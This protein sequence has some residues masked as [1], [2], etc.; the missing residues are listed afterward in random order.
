MSVISAQRLRECQGFIDKVG[1]IRF[2]KVK[3][4][5]LNKYNILLNKKEGNITWA[6][7]TT[8]TNS[9]NLASQLGRQAST[10]LPPRE[11]SNLSQVSRQAG[12]LLPPGEGSNLSQAGTLLPLWEGSS[13]SQAIAY[14]P[15]GEG[16]SSSQTTA[17]LPPGEASSIS[18]AI[19]HLP[20][21]EGSNLS[22]AGRQS[23]TLLSHGEGSGSSQ[24]I[25][26][27]PP[28]KEAILCQQLCTF[29]PGKEA[30]LPRLLLTFPQGK[31]TVLPRLPLILP[32][33]KE[34]VIPRQVNQAIKLGQAGRALGIL[35]G[36]G[37]SR[38]PRRIALSPGK[39]TPPLPSPVGFPKGLLMKNLTLSG[40]LTFPAN[41]WL[42]LKGL[43]LIKDPTLQFPPGNLLT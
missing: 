42:Q 1:E 28:G 41:L 26:H 36:I 11:G 20:P 6:N 38:L 7:A 39:T 27:L 3:Q 14:L 19:A 23:G 2:T 43:F 32:W 24:A 5:H 16:S 22:Q 4:R 9:N 18:Q 40:S 17:H 8:P 10:P 30:V 31:V 34:V 29:L 37:H 12:T 13:S 25:G 15:P 33:W 35:P 21:G